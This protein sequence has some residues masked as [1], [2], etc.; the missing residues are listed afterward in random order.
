MIHASVHDAQ[1]EQ[2]RKDLFL[3]AWYHENRDLCVNRNP[4]ERPRDTRNCNVARQSG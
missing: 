2:Q 1:F 4:R 3:R